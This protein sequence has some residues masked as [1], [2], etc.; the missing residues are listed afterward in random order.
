MGATSATGVGIG[1]S[2]GKQKPE[3]H[4]TCGG[5]KPDEKEAAP[6]RKRGCVVR[7]ISGG[8]VRNKS[9]ITSRIRVC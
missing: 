5:G 1:D 6:P 2:D 3:N 7:H 9:G 8:I 4:I